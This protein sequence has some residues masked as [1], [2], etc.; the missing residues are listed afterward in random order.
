MN[1]N[2]KKSLMLSFFVLAGSGTFSLLSR[3]WG[4]DC[5]ECCHYLGLYGGLAALGAAE[6]IADYTD[7]K[8]WKDYFAGTQ[9]LIDAIY[10][11]DLNKVRALI[12][13]GVDINRADRRGNTPLSYAIENWNTPV[14]QLLINSKVDV[15]KVNVNGDTP[16]IQAIIKFSRLEDGIDLLIKN[17]ADVNQK[18]ESGWMSLE[19]VILGQKDINIAKLLIKYGAKLLAKEQVARWIQGGEQRP[20]KR[21]AENY[22]SA[23]KAV[24]EDKDLSD[25]IRN[26]VLEAIE[27][28]TKERMRMS[29]N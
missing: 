16:L 17:G 3:D 11:R 12:K 21:F 22:L 29:Y 20:G 26:N 15:N 9:D 27:Y 23:L 18:G 24:L 28:I 6:T 1:I 8:G 19:G 25:K 2:L 10:V 7:Y 13:K 4:R 14:M 5:V